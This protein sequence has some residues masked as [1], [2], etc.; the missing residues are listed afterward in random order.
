MSGKSSFS[1]ETSLTVFTLKAKAINGICIGFAESKTE[2]SGS[3]SLSLPL[4]TFLTS[5][6]F[7]QRRIICADCSTWRTIESD[8]RRRRYLREVSFAHI[9][10]LRQSL[11]TLAYLPTLTPAWFL[12]HSSIWG[13]DSRGCC[14]SEKL[15]VF[16]AFFC[17]FCPLGFFGFF[18]SNLAD[19]DVE[20]RELLGGLNSYW[21]HWLR[22]W[23]VNIERKNKII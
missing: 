20:R 22:I 10:V 23:S 21:I 4:L 2:R 12:T 7:H 14:W 16:L 19:F 15:S 13:Y 11:L 18:R 1:L 6:V 5:F 8:Y 17:F 3:W 9:P